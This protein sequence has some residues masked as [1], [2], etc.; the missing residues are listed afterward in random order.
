MCME[1]SFQ[2]SFEQDIIRTFSTTDD[3]N[4]LDMSY[5]SMSY[6]EFDANAMDK[7]SAICAKN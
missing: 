1:F 7:D 5:L 3:A 2:S 4:V 6:V